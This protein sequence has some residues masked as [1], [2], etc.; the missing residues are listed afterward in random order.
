MKNIKNFTLRI[1]EKTLEQFGIIANK[2]KRSINSQLIL[3]IE[4][5]IEEN[6]PLKENDN[7]KN[8]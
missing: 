4:K 6:S 3:L 2:E 8:N 7:K 5:F 1:D